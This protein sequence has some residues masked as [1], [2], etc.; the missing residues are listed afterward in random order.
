MYIEL[1]LILKLHDSCHMPK[2]PK[3]YIDA[4]NTTKKKKGI[5]V[6]GFILKLE[7]HATKILKYVKNNFFYH[8]GMLNHINVEGL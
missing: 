3:T 5:K 1:I 7:P 4:K 2:E 8:V 6:G